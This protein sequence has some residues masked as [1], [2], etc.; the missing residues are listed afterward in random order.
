MDR[1]GRG[2]GLVRRLEEVP[3]AAG[4]V[5]FEAV[6]RFVAAFADGQ[7]VQRAVQ[8][9]VAAVIEAVAIG[10]SRGGRDR[11]G[12]GQSGDALLLVRAGQRAWWDLELGP[13]VVQPPAQ[14]VDQP[15]A[16]CDESLAMVDDQPHVKLRARQLRDR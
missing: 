7:A 5:A 13:E 6:Q 2:S 16:L 4:G 9:A 12:A 14:L 3:D 10:A 1:D 8:L 15:C 11:R